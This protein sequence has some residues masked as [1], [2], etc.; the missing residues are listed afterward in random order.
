MV[1]VYCA[2]SVLSAALQASLGATGTVLVSG[3]AGF[4][5]AHSTA[6]SIAAQHLAG[7]VETSTALIASLTAL[8]TNSLSKVALAWTGRHLLFGVWTTAG[9]VLITLSAWLTLLVY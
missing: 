1:A 5:D 9:V 4:I 7:Q 6:G 3:T 8:T 2:V